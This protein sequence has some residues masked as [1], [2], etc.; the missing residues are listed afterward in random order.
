MVSF[1]NTLWGFLLVYL[2]PFIL[3]LDKPHFAYLLIILW[4]FEFFHVLAIMNNAAMN[5]VGKSL[6]GHIFPF[7]FGEYQNGITGFYGKYMFNFLRNYFSKAA[8][9]FYV[10]LYLFYSF[11]LKYSCHIIILVLRI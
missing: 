5:F 1:A 10:F 9:L 7:L 2:C 3:V 8:V 11:L 6:G 4:I